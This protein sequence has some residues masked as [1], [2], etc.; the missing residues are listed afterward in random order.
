MLKTFR[1]NRR[2][3]LRLRENKRTLQDGLREEGETLGAPSC[4]RRSERARLGNVPRD[5]TGMRVDMRL[6]CCTKRGMGGVSF[7]HHRTE[8]AGELGQAAVEQGRAKIDVAEQPRPRVWQRAVG[9]RGEGGLGGR[10][11]VLGGG[12][13]ELFLACEMMEEAALGQPGGRADVVDGRG[14][15]AL[16]ADHMQR[17]VQQPGLRRVLTTCLGHFHTLWLV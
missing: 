17:R 13:R 3:T 10:G 15:V 1:G 8:E 12:E 7:L 2:A 4:V 14:G 6:A 16:G 11:E 9:R 5:A